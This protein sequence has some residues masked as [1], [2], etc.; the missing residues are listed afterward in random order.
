MW[1]RNERE[2]DGV[3][4]AGADNDAAGRAEEV[5]DGVGVGAGHRCSGLCPLPPKIWP[6]LRPSPA[7][8]LAHR[9][10]RQWPYPMLAEGKRDRGG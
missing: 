6:L 5:V 3:T 7:R 4:N 10:R 1:R 2:R 9:R 8:P